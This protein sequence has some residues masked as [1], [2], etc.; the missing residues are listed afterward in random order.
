MRPA[1]LAIVSGWTLRTDIDDLTDRI[2]RAAILH[3]TYPSA[4]TGA[5]G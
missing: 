4:T 2:E 3:F 1:F 5:W